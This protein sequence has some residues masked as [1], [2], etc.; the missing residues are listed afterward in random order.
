M[1]KVKTLTIILTIVLVTMVA[2]VGVYTQ[3]QNRMTNKVKDY[4]YA[5]DLKGTRNIRLKVA[6]DTKTTIKDAD[7]N[8]VEGSEDLT[9]EQIQE[10]GY[11]KEETPSNTEEVLNKENYNKSKKII[12]E[13]LK[14]LN[15]DNYTLKVDETTG[16]ILIEIPENDTTDSIVSNIATVGKFEIVDSE[17][18][19]VLMD[20]N[21]IKLSNV[22]YGSDSSATSSSSGTVV[23]LNIEFNKEGKKKLE[24][25]SGKYV[26]TENSDSTEGK[27]ETEDTEKTENTETTENSKDTE[28]TTEKK[29]TMK[30]DDEEIMSTSFDEPI[31]TGK[32]QLS[33]GSSTTDE[34]TLKGYVEQASNMATILDTGRIPVKYEVEE[35]KYVL[36]DIT[37]NELN[38]VC[39]V[40][41]GIAILG[42]IVLIL[43][44]KTSGL[45]GAISYVGLASIFLLIIRY[46]NVV[47]SIE[48][49]FGIA[50]TLIL[51]YI[52]INKLLFK[53]KNEMSE[54]TTM[55]DVMK[56]TYKEYLIKIIPICIAVITFCFINW[57]P[58]SSFGMVMF[59]GIALIIIYNLLI[60]NNLL[61]IKANK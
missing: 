46:A 27:D 19:E 26:K 21:D 13:R 23:Y 45:L 3:Q 47:L 11:T 14:K 52:L 36:S 18:N 9:D 35:N 5:M 48:G 17:T 44:Y 24:D 54:E 50:I 42:L 33:V 29:I 4:S 20:N 57:A 12:E 22:L 61:K 51:N 30:I 31:T 55:K 16:D 58:I 40:I 10:K 7:G 39:Y 53:L 15:I 43:K 41:T 2:F 28:S 59:W 32:L 8:E 1:K 56:K 37:T 34:K 60:T 38:I 6:T 25:I 49:I